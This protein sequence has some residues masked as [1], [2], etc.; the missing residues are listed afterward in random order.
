MKKIVIFG[1]AFN[2]PHIGH[3]R[4][5]EV[6]L[7]DFPAD[8]F[9]IM[10]SADRYDKKVS[11]SGDQRLRMVA[12]MI[13]ELFPASKIPIILSD[14]E[15]KRPRPTVTYE[16]KEELEKTYPDYE[17]YFLIGSDSLA[18]VENKWVR[19]K[20]LYETA[21]F[22]VL[23]R[24]GY[25][26]PTKLPPHLTKIHWSPSGNISSTEIKKMLS[27]GESADNLLSK[28][29]ADYIKRNRLYKESESIKGN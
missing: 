11:V 3:A 17:F 4:V 25:L 9:W 5:I 29:V 1:G 26:L 16:T 20:K 27:R 7:K 23:E 24:P 15:I 18:D 2:P 21:N 14:L 28:G 10:P 12:I 22:V 8:E 6:V 19:G 13:N